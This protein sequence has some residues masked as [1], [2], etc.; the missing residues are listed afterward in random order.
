MVLELSD[1]I[2]I[3][4]QSLSSCVVLGKLFNLSEPQF[5][6]LQKGVVLMYYI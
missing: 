1:W 6:D 3:M 5:S 4:G 2:L